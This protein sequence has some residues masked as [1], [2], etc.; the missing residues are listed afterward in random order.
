M[1]NDV[2]CFQKEITTP[3]NIA[4][5]YMDN[6]GDMISLLDD[7]D[8][9]HA[10]SISSLL[11]VTI[12]DKS[13]DKLTAQAVQSTTNNTELQGSLLELRDKLNALIESFEK[14]SINDSSV[15]TNDSVHNKATRRLTPAE[16]AEFLG[17]S[18]TVNN[19]ETALN[20]SVKELTTLSPKGG[21]V[22]YYPPP[23]AQPVN[24]KQSQTAQQQ[25]PQ[26]THQQHAQ[27]TPQTTQQ[28]QQ[29]QQ[30]QYPPIQ[31]QQQAQQPS[32]QQQQQPQYIQTPPVSSGMP[33]Q[34]QQR[35]VSMQQF[36]SQGSQS[37]I[38]PSPFVPGTPQHY[39]NPTNYPPSNNNADP[40][41]PRQ[42]YYVPPPPSSMSTPQIPP[43]PYNVPPPPS[44]RW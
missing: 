28:H 12:Y 37:N 34:Q 5:K 35:P 9:T 7:I 44:G 8:I 22:P 1:F 25:Q 19:K 31:Q 23:T 3:E 21:S 15:A 17:D 33:Q 43:Q 30:S 13:V 14:T 11:K 24:Q 36:P 18:S 42:G 27:Y 2:P 40:R 16:L 10:I 6:E 20:A 4:L 26:K 32:A 39:S 41:L 38:P 29:P